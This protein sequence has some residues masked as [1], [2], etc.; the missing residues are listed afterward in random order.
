MPVLLIMNKLTTAKERNEYSLAI[1]LDLKNE[2]DT[3]NYDILFIKLNHY[4]IRGTA[5]KLIQNYLSHRHQL[6]SYNK[7]LSST[8]LLKT[9]VP[10]G[11]IL[12]PLL[13]ILYINDFVNVSSVTNSFLFADDAT[14]LIT[15]KNITEL[16]A[17]ANKELNKF[18]AWFKTNKLSLNI[19]KTKYMLYLPVANRSS[20][21][22]NYKIIIN[23]SEIEKVHQFTL[24][25][26]VLDDCMSWQ[27]HITKIQNKILSFIGILY[28]IR[29]KIDKTTSLL[30]YD[31]II[32]S[33]L[34]YCNVVWG[35]GYK[36]SLEGL[37][38]CQKRALKLCLKLPRRTE[39]EK[40]FSLSNKLTVYELNNLHIATLAYMIINKNIAELLTTFF[41]PTSSIHSYNNRAKLNLQVCFAKSNIRKFSPAVRGPV[42]WNSI[43]YAIKDSNSLSQF[44]KRYKIYLIENRSK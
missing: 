10:Q 5:L 32:A 30:L 40:V 27:Y 4:G 33:H 39:T 20:F 42:I 25:G 14:T 23:N 36:T 3:I 7:V 35:F 15:R 1:F 22:P 6:V 34:N 9:G 2:F 11:S 44:K 16:F 12:G 26:V 37:Y 38:S 8:Q 21:Q 13:F 19:Q 24:L 17:V 18:D 29:E 43:P 31:S 41:M 28:K